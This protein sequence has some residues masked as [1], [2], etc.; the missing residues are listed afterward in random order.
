M[1]CI[2]PDAEAMQHAKALERLSL[3]VKPD[4]GAVLWTPHTTTTTPP[5]ILPVNVLE[6]VATDLDLR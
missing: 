4:H 3:S 1:I 6:A 2:K 5:G